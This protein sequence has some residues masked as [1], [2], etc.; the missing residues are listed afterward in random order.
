MNTLNTSRGFRGLLATTVFAAL[1]CSLTAACAAADTMDPPQTTVK[2]ADLNI[3]NPE[4]AAVL[5]GRIHRAALQVCR[6]FDELYFRS[7]AHAACV[8][9]AIADAVTK[10][11]RPALSMV[12]NAH[13][14]QPT[15][16][17]LATRR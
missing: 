16:I 13:N 8:H 17:V 1:A 12:Y 9:K 10:V 2:F 6:A 14:G 3:S 7:P 4:G 15:P 11:D 5:Y